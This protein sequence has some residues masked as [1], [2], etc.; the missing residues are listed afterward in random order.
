MLGKLDIHFIPRG[1]ND[2]PLESIEF[3]APL[4][5]FYRRA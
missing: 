1:A 5:A 4:G 3:S 2:P